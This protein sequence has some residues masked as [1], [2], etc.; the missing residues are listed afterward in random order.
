MTPVLLAGRS[1]TDNFWGPLDL[2][3]SLILHVSIFLSPIIFTQKLR[4]VRMV[5]IYFL[6]FQ[7]FSLFFWSFEAVSNAIKF[8]MI[9]CHWL[10]PKFGYFWTTFHRSSSRTRILCPRFLYLKRIA[11]RIV[12]IGVNY[13]ANIMNLLVKG[14]EGTSGARTHTSGDFT[15]NQ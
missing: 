13:T 7:I 2:K 12:Y 9:I 3:L 10:A 11:A 14:F 1:E 6:R 15:T 8:T 5:E 4:I